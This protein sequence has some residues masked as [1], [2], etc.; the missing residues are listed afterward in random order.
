MN[1][2]A[3]YEKTAREW[4]RMYARKDVVTEKEQL[5]RVHECSDKQIEKAVNRGKDRNYVHTVRIDRNTH[6]V[7]PLHEPLE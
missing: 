6:G 7:V 4:V 1:N 5:V 3:Q 2:H